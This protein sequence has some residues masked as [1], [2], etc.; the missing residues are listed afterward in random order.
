MAG[1]LTRHKAL[2]HNQSQYYQSGTVQKCDTRA[3]KRKEKQRRIPICIVEHK[4]ELTEP[5]TNVETNFNLQMTD[6]IGT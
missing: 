2:H 5:K 1:Q 3:R 4:R 6:Q